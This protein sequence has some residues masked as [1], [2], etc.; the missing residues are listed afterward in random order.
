MQQYRNTWR[1]YFTSA[2]TGAVCE[3]GSVKVAGEFKSWHEKASSAVSGRS[4]ERNVRFKKVYKSGFLRGT[5]RLRA[6]SAA[7]NKN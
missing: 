1:L 7:E 5:H 4:G 6:A 2:V 3:R